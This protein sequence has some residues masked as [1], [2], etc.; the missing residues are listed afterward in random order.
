M[1]SW[2]LVCISNFCLYTLYYWTPLYYSTTTTLFYY[3]SALSCSY[4]TQSFIRFANINAKWKLSYNI[5]SCHKVKNP[6]Q[7]I[8][9]LYVLSGTILQ[10]VVVVATIGASPLDPMHW[11]FR[12]PN[13]LGYTTN[14]IFWRRETDLLNCYQL[15]CSISWSSKPVKTVLSL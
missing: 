6:N 14:K 9:N 3:Y 13:P 12:F 11:D 15:M 7:F 1:S 5:S 8:L 4:T 2:A 10:A